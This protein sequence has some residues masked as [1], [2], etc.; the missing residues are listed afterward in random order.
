MANRYR[1]EIEARL[2]EKDYR[3][4]LT[5][6]AL[7]ELEDAFGVEDMIAVAKRFEGGR[8]TS[9]D[10]MKIIG[11]GLRAAGNDVSDE[12]VG[13]M[14]VEGGA[15]GYVDIVARLLRATFAPE[16][17]SEAISGGEGEGNSV[18]FPGVK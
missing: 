3:L 2:D 12:A 18:P 11:A 13:A 5:L 16:E 10:A 15:K 14:Q 1:G 17:S 6:G 9:S 7:A 8:I 4:F